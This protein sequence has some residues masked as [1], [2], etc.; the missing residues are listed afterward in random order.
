MPTSH[1]TSIKLRRS[2]NAPWI[3]VLTAAALTMFPSCGEHRRPTSESTLRAIIA[4]W[5]NI[6]RQRLGL[7][8]SR[9]VEL[10]RASCDSCEEDQPCALLIYNYHRGT[11]TAVVDWCKPG[12][13]LTQFG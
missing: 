1:L 5:K 8:P 4:D 3:I 13:I 10:E 11:E 2:T 7:N 12:S 9:H 6:L